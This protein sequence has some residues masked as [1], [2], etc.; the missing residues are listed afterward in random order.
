MVGRLAARSKLRHYQSMPSLA[1][2]ATLKHRSHRSAWF[3]GF[4][5]NISI[6]CGPHDKNGRG[7]NCFPLD[8]LQWTTPNALA[9]CQSLSV[10]SLSRDALWRGMSCTA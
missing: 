9:L 7:W 3:P 4:V 6:W 1:L 10:R 5:T 2:W 8:S